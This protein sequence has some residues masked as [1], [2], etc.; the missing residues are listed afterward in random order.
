M[1][2]KTRNILIPIVEDLSRKKCIDNSLEI[3]A[4]V[5]ERARNKILKIPILVAVTS[6]LSPEIYLD[7]KKIMLQVF[8]LFIISYFLCGEKELDVNGVL[9]QLQDIK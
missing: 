2:E 3:S 7:K 5:L 4:D 8:V 9:A 6:Q 1:G